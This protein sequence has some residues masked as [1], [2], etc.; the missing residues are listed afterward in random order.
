MNHCWVVTTTTTL[1]SVTMIPSWRL[2]AAAAV[3]MMRE[4]LE[5]GLPLALAKVAGVL[6]VVP[7]AAVL[8]AVLAVDV[9]GE[10]VFALM[11]WLWNL[12]AEDGGCRS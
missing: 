12:E 9:D 10:A 7:D 5:V 4:L 11:S 3:A 6:V 8:A 1:G 2:S